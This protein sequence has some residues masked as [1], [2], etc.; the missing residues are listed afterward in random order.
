MKFFQNFAL[1]FTGI[2]VGP[3][4]LNLAPA[5]AATFQFNY[6]FGSGETLSG[7][8][9]GDLSPDND[10]V[11]GLRNLSA[12]FSS[13]LNSINFTEIPPFDRF[14]QSSFCFP[15][16]TLSLSGNNPFRLFG[17]NFSGLGTGAGFLLVDSLAAV[18]PVEIASDQVFIG[19]NF[20]EP[21]AASR[22]QVNQVLAGPESVPEPN[23]ILGFLT[24]ATVSITLR[25]K[26]PAPD[27]S[28]KS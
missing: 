7:R 5:R 24:F 4:M 8:V 1:A 10:T 25:K 17:T 15:E 6:M 26:W 20:I 14:V 16:C 2:I 11:T 3:A 9:D 19:D 27:V 23:T 18:G 13:G 22:W 21:F 12:S 28:T